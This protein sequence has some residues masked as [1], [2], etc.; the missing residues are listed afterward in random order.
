ENKTLTSHEQLMD[1]EPREVFIISALLVPIIGIGLY[2]KLLTQ[3]YDV[4]TQQLTAR[5]REQVPSLAQKAPT[6]TI[7]QAFK[8]EFLKAPN[9]NRV[10]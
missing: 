6:E 3:I 8:P 5:L 4:K 7:L 9:L 2:P 10:Q 1:A